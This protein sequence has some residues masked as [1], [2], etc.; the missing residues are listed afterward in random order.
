MKDFNINIG[1]SESIVLV[2]RKGNN[3]L[4]TDDRNAINACKLLNLNY[5]TAID[6]LI[7]IKENRFLTKEEANSKLEK[8]IVYGRYKKQII[9]DAKKRLR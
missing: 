9:E 5:T 7:I 2:M 4:A 3:I 6:I 8:L 1:E